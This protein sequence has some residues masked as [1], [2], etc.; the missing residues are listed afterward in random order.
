RSCRLENH[1]DVPVFIDKLASMTLDFTAQPLEL[2][3]LP[4]AHVNERQ[5]TRE[6][7]RYGQKRLVSR[8]GTTSH[9][10]NNAAALVS[11]QTNEFFGE[12]YG[13]ALV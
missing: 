8:R 6:T 13:F 5:L 7:I 9:Q 12:A 4:G 10:M 1:S 2:I 11:P 3:S